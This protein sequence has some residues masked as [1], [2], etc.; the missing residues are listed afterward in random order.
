MKPKNKMPS[1]PL[2]ETRDKS[3]G[4]FKQAGHIKNKSSNLNNKLLGSLQ[5]ENLNNEITSQSDISHSHSTQITAKKEKYN[6]LFN[7]LEEIKHQQ[8]TSV[9]GLSHTRTSKNLKMPIK[10][11][12]HSVQRKFQMW[13]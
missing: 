13:S 2:G 9:R 8:Q 12:V 1:T 3:Q 10:G 4:K 11:S 6:E 7:K 5:S